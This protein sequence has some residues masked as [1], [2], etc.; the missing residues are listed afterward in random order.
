[1]VTG[2]GS[3]IGWA[4]DKAFAHADAR[5]VASDIDE[6]AGT[7]VVQLFAGSARLRRLSSPAIRGWWTVA[8]LFS[9]VVGRDQLT[10]SRT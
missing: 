7:R 4:A 3:G 10:L 8:T 9:S 2:G 1:L 6:E 5:V